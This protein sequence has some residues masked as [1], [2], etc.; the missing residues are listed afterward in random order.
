MVFG[1]AHFRGVEATHIS[2]NKAEAHRHTWVVRSVRVVLIAVP[3]HFGNRKSE[4][5][6]DN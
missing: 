1:I 4:P 3:Y 5:N 2:P 6:L